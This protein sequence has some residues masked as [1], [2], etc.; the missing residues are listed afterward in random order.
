D[1][2]GEPFKGVD[3]TR[4]CWTGLAVQADRAERARAV[5][6]AETLSDAIAVG[7]M[8]LK[9]ARSV[10]EEAQRTGLAH[11]V[12]LAGW[13]AKAEAEWIRLQGHSDPKAWQA[14]IDAFSFGHVYEV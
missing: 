12:F 10:E 3:D 11:H 4:T 9:R 13:L 7:R 2:T 6:D 5:G 8:L 14:A 1:A